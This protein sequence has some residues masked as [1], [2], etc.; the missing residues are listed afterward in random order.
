MAPAAFACIDAPD[1][2]RHEFAFLGLLE[3]LPIDLRQHRKIDVADL[4]TV[5]D[6]GYVPLGGA[7]NGL[8]RRLPGSAPDEFMEL[9]KTAL[10]NGEFD[11]G[12]EEMGE[13]GV[14][15]LRTAGE[16]CK[17]RY[18]FTRDSVVRLLLRADALPTDPAV[19]ESLFDVFA[20]MKGETPGYDVLSSTPFNDYPERG[21]RELEALMVRRTVLANFLRSRYRVVSPVGADANQPPVLDLPPANENFRLIRKPAQLRGRPCKIAWPRIVELARQ[22]ASE[23]PDWQ[24]KRLAFEA[25]S[26]ARDKFNE[27][28]LPSVATILRSMVE[29]LDS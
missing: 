9:F 26:R 4:A 21:R 8:S 16:T 28:E 3:S 17:R 12:P 5:L 20:I 23:H 6:D 19:R 11:D 7:A 22:L 24:R 18:G 15:W 2:P 1:I 27:D 29:I 13:T 25:W 10:F 14:E